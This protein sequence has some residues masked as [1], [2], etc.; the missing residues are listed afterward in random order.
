MNSNL[1]GIATLSLLVAGAPVSAPADGLVAGPLWSD[2]ELTLRP[3]HR[4]EALGPLVDRE[5]NPDFQSWSLH[6]LIHYR[7]YGKADITQWEM[8]YPLLTYDRFGVQYKY[9]FLYLFKIVGGREI[10]EEE[11]RKFSL[12]PF[13]FWEKSKKEDESYFA[14]FPFGG[15]LKHRLFRD[16]I[17]FYLF[18]AYVKTRK[19]DVVTR[20]ILYPVWH[21]RTGN[22]LKGWQ[23][24][25]LVGKEYKLPYTMTNTWGDEEL[26]PGH[27]R[28]FF[29]WP[30]ILNS[31]EGIGTDNPERRTSVLPFYDRLRSPRRDSITFLWP[32]F[33]YIDD[34]A[35]Q[36][37][38]YRLP[39]PFFVFSRGE[40]KHLNRIFPFYSKGKTD[41]YETGFY[42]WPFYRY[43]RRHLPPLDRTRKRVLFFLYSDARERN[44]DEDLTRRRTYMWP[45]FTMRKDA[46]GNR[47][48]QVFAPLEPLVGEN[49]TFER[50][51]SPLWSVWRSETNGQTHARSESLL[52]NLYRRQTTEDSKKIS[53]LFG[54]FQYQ[55]NPERKRWRIFYVPFGGKRNPSPAVPENQ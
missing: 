34:R 53:I 29:L 37:H 25:P 54:L 28:S 35:Q 20:N 15:T 12:W 24:W 41:K 40:G 44:L 22:H 32:F 43:S 16:E 30:F 47:R 27:T 8:L 9:Q 42:L 39:W 23:F 31:V 55:S 36:Y 17:N 48:W 1:I 6:P 21:A 11:E 19:R 7:K 46:S 3:G 38:E 10:T 51:W 49:P 18:P 26:V 45:F 5:E 14:F 33:S 50:N 4:V 2:F 13:L 52:W